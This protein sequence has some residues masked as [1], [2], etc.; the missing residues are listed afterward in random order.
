M[1]FPLRTP[2]R[3]EY[4]REMDAIV[5]NTARPISQTWGLAG[6]ARLNR[7]VPSFRSSR[8][9]KPIGVAGK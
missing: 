6:R 8:R 5:T 1:I 2:L 7:A 9:R 3:A 4:G